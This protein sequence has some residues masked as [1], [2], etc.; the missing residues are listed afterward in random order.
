MCLRYELRF[1]K[2]CNPA[3]SVSPQLDGI[4]EKQLIGE[5]AFLYRLGVYFRQTST[6][7]DLTIQPL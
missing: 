5:I 7:L 2:L 6:C 1:V 3:M 4:F